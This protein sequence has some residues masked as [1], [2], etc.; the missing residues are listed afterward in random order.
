[1]DNQHFSRRS[2]SLGALLLALLLCIG[3]VL[4]DAQVVNGAYWAERSKIKITE[5]ETVDGARGQIL[6]RYGRV[7]VSNQVTYQV[8][9]NPSVMGD[10]R[11]QIISQ[12][13]DAA[14]RSGISWEDNLPIS[15]QP[16]FTYVGDSPFYAVS[17]DDDGNLKKTLTRLGRLAVKMKWIS[18][19]PTSTTQ[20][21]SLPSADEL[22]GKMC[23]SFGIA[24]EGALDP[25]KHDEVSVLNIGDMSP[26]QARAIAGVLYETYL[27]SKDIYYIPYVFAEDVDIDFISQVKER[28]L[29]GVNIDAVTKR[30]Y[31]TPYAAHLLGS[32]GPIY[33]EEWDR[34]KT[35]DLDGDGEADYEMD[36]R[37]GKSGAESAFESYLRGTPGLRQVDRD[38]SGRA[39]DE[40]WIT[41]PD[42]GHNV[43][44]TLDID[45]QQ[46]VEEA[47]AHGLPKLA[48]DE[49]EGAACVVLDV[50]NGDVLAAAS[51]PTYN[52]TT[53][54][55]DYNE[56]AANPLRPFLNRAFMGLYA[57]GSTFK[58]VTAIAGLEEGIVTPRTIIE[59]NGR[60]TYYNK[61]GPMCWI[62][63]QYFRTHGK[64]TVTDAIKNSCNIYFYDV[65]RQLTIDRLQE[66]AGYFGL[67]QK[68][69]IELPESTGT[70]AGPTTPE[71]KSAWQ[72]GS[73]LSVAIGQENSQFTPLQLANYI[74]TL[75]NGGTHYSAHLLKSVKSSD[76]SQVIY[77]QEPNVLNSIDIDPKNLEAVKQGMLQLTTEGSV[78]YYFRDVGVPVGAK[79]GSAQVSA[80]TESHGHFVCFAPYDDPQI[81][82]AISVEHGG[83][84]SDVGA[85]A[86]EIVKYYFSAEETREVILTENT[87]IR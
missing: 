74:A 46:V 77:T 4:Y 56:N 50:N 27:R 14:R 45:L 28:K 83:S 13:I 12:L 23:A 64:Q 8:T 63:R 17:R 19:D 15:S 10:N 18:G 40:V 5:T 81:A 11:G 1:M 21:V 73:T 36:D 51:Y 31:N 48:S 86:A 26:Q 52:L 61:N 53:Y 33:Q 32:I 2:A 47:L 35:I 37:V 85:I 84:G 43:I 39:V 25:S 30:Q 66:Y 72:P 71:E 6:D 49:V 75:V 24:G 70:M 42:P 58:M 3:A 38:T 57:P 69:G 20:Q 87:L 16:P 62:Y 60:Y 29:A 80:N 55:A 79:T 67:G 59:D 34:Y 41:Q 68:T 78:S 9:L 76:F 82:I 7:L 65:G 22:L 54:S 44:L